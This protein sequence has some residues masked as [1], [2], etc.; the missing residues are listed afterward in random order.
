MEHGRRTPTRI[1]SRISHPSRRERDIRTLA[2][3]EGSGRKEGRYATRRG[4]RSTRWT[5]GRAQAALGQD[6]LP[7]GAALGRGR[8]RRGDPQREREPFCRG[9]GHNAWRLG[10]FLGARRLGAASVVFGTAAI[11]FMAAASTGLIPGIAP[12]GHGYN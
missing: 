5:R 12:L 10:Y 6:L 3:R 7:G 8:L 4:N 11:F 9:S 2:R 1:A